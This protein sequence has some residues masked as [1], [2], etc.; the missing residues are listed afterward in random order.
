MLKPVK[1][2][3]VWQKRN[4]YIK[5]AVEQTNLK[6]VR[7]STGCSS[8][9]C[10]ILQTKKRLYYGYNSKKTHPLQAEFGKNKEAIFLHAEIAAIVKAISRED[11]DS[12]KG[13]TLYIARTHADGTIV[14]SKPCRGCQQAL[15]FFEV[16]CLYTNG[17]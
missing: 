7:L 12:I 11:R 6:E 17:K 16:D 2:T 13:S 15:E 5:K 14:N 8:V 9:H 4:I 10:A 3:E 1:A